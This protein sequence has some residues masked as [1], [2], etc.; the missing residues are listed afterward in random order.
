ME[1]EQLKLYQYFVSF[2]YLA[3][4]CY[5]NG[6]EFIRNSIPNNG[7]FN[8]SGANTWRNLCIYLFLPDETQEK[9]H[10]R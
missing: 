8:W 4:N 5:S 10:I 7:N 3:L 2:C 1:N 6:F 9:I